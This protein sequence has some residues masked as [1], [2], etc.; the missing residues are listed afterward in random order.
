MPQIHGE[1]IRD[2]ISPGLQRDRSQ[3]DQEYSR[4]LKLFSIYGNT[5]HTK[6]MCCLL[7]VS[8]MRALDTRRFSPPHYM[9][10]G[11][12]TPV[13]EAF[14]LSVMNAQP[15]GTVIS[16]PVLITSVP[17]K[18]KSA[19]SARPRKMA[20]PGTCDRARKVLGLWQSQ[21]S[22]GTM[23]E[24]GKYGRARKVWQSQES[25][26]TMAEPGKYGRARKVWQSQESTGTMA[27]P[28]KYGRARKVWQSQEST[29]T[30]AEPGKYGRARKVWQSQESTGTMA[31][32]GKYGRARKVWQSQEN[33]GTMA[34]PEM[35]WAYDRARKV[36]G[37]WQSQESTGP[38][39]EP[40]CGCL[41]SQQHASVSH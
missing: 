31:E 36:L 34:E 1:S 4:C 7:C 9:V 39:A 16:R 27:E 6:E 28:G 33:T 25:T 24:P 19:T 37:L 35:Y 17:A 10:R 29:G 5:L 23:A 21:E 15:T 18:D 12:T 32:P 13:C 30:M 38:M 8:S 2:E 22:T 40:L 20:E 26:G 14:K 11:D 3:A 41:T